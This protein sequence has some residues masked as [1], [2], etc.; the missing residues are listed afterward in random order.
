MDLTKRIHQSSDLSFKYGIAVLN[1]HLH[2][3]LKL[4]EDYI[5]SYPTEVIT[6]DMRNLR[7]DCLY[8]TNST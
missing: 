2:K 1:R 5:V 8:K 7:M 6:R 3:Y 4:K